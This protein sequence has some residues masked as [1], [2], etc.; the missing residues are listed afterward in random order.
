MDFT[1]PEEVLDYRDMIKAFGIKHVRPSAEERD[2]H[3]TWDPQLWRKMGEVGLL[4]LSI[5]VEYGGQGASCLMTTVAHEAFGEGSLDG[6]LTLALGAHAIIGSM[7]IVLCGTEEQKKR[8]LPKI[9]TGE[10]TSGLGL[11]EPGSGSDAAG[12]METRAIKKGDRYILNG[13][14]MFITNGPIGDVFIVMAVT[15]KSKGAMG[16]SVFIVE[17]NF[18]GFKVGKKLEKMGMRTSLTSELIF[19]DMEVPEENRIEKENSGF[20]RVGRATLEWERTV[21]VAA[22]IGSMQAMLDDGVRHAKQRQQFGEPIIRFQAI[23]DK[24]A[25]A[26]MKLDAARLLI[27]KSAAKK[28]KGQAAPIESSIAKVYATESANEV[29]YDMGQV[30]GGYCFIHEYPVER[31]YR[32]ARLGTLG[33][34]TSEVMRSIIAANT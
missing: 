24:I 34:G 33:G 4:G 7:P 12:S 14:K 6:G 32:D 22:S 21:L 13:S 31:A 27:Y 30:F 15:D 11:T 18:K 25:R 29:A 3:G 23:Q 17:K 20:A 26:R 1:L 10:Y 8:Y 19:E 9:A 28:D 16:I 2:L 5:P